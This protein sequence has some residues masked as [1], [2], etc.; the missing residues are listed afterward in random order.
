MPFQKIELDR[1]AESVITQIEQLILRGIIRPG[2]RLPSERDLADRLGVS[3]PSLREA[4]STLQ[5]RG[6]LT[7]KANAGVFVAELLGA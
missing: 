7:T 4:I 3:R 1:V 2:E 6:L 5:D